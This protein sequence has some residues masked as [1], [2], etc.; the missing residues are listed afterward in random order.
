M[1]SLMNNAFGASGVASS[2]AY[3]AATGWRQVLYKKEKQNR[4]LLDPHLGDAENTAEVEEAEREAKKAKVDEASSS[5][6]RHDPESRGSRSFFLCQI[7]Q[8]FSKLECQ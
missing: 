5:R 1:F 3:R 4:L 2:E 7:G 8:N 6:K